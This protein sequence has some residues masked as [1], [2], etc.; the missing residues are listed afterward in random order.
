[1]NCIVYVLLVASLYLF[2]KIVER[3]I[4]IVLGTIALIKGVENKQNGDN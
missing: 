1:M 3:F 4:S 2:P